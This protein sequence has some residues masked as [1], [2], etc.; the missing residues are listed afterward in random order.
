MEPCVCFFRLGD[1][2]VCECVEGGGHSPDDCGCCGRVGGRKPEVINAMGSDEGGKNEEEE[3]DADEED[4]KDEEDDEDDED[5]EAE[6]D[7]LFCCHVFCSVLF[8]LWEKVLFSGVVR[9]RRGPCF[10]RVVIMCCAF[11]VN[12]VPRF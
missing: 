2:M 4:E 7:I 5:E 12:S 10:M 9:M 6:D 1:D 11:S 8:N 3:A